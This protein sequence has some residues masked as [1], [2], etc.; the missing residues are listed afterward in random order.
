RRRAVEP[1]VFQ[2]VYDH[3]LQE[4]GAEKEGDWWVIDTGKI[5]NRIAPLTRNSEVDRWPKTVCVTHDIEGGF[6]HRD[7]D[8]EFAR[9]ADRFAPDALEK[10]LDIEAEQGVK[11]TYN[12]LGSLYK[13]VE[14]KI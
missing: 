5:R 6:G 4:V 8:P 11:A 7:V 9:D 10:M 2:R 12:V 1:A 14:E 13:D 3:T